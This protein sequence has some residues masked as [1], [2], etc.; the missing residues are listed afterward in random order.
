MMIPISTQY[1]SCKMNFLITCKQ[2][3][4]KYLTVLLLLSIIGVG[5]P[6]MADT[7][8]N[9]S[10]TQSTQKITKKAD[11]ESEGEEVRQKGTQ[12]DE[13][14]E[15]NADR[16][17]KPMKQLAPKRSGSYAAASSSGSSQNNQTPAI[18]TANIDVTQFSGA[19]NVSIPIL[20]PPGRAGLQ[21]NISLNYNSN[22]GNGWIGMGWDIDM[23]SIQRSQTNRFNFEFQST[24][25]GKAD[26]VSR[27]DWGS[28][29]YGAKIEG[30]FVKYYYNISTY[31]VCKQKNDIFDHLF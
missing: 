17:K 3:F 22:R 28:N 21:P 10:D 6:V 23:G 14:R 12:E 31:A 26:L 11:N 27:P 16:A 7:D 18:S 19:A 24:S 13:N 2:T 9:K 5:Y 20:V 29:Y 4:I 8:G 25:A 15:S 1:H 30:E